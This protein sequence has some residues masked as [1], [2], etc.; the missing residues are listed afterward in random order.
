[1]CLEDK[2]WACTIDSFQ[3]RPE[4]RV[5]CRGVPVF[6]SCP[7]NADPPVCRAGLVHK[8]F[9]IPGIGCEQKRHALLVL[10]KEILLQQLELSDQFSLDRLLDAA[11]T[12][13]LKVFLQ[14]SM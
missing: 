10:G 4:E 1:L 3:L 12:N 11:I 8:K 9:A 13:P 7:E 6:L 14:Y 2:L 5:V